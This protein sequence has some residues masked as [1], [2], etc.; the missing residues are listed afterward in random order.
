MTSPYYN[1]CPTWTY[2]ASQC[3]KPTCNYYTTC[4]TCTNIGN[5]NWCNGDESCSNNT[6][7]CREGPIIS[8]S[9][10]CTTTE[11]TVFAGPIIGIVFGSI[12]LVVLITILIVCCCRRCQ[13]TNNTGST[14]V[15]ASSVYQTSPTPIPM[16]MTA[17]ALTPTY[18]PAQYT[19]QP[20]MIVQPAGMQYQPIMG[21]QPTMIVQPAGMQQYVVVQPGVQPM[22]GDGFQRV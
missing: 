14:I 22:G 1:T 21:T 17:T 3:Y 13:R 5:C 4:S 18:I 12:V 19:Q 10:I 6:W 7:N 9:G 15:Q 20:T 11:P 8:A 2:S 16:E